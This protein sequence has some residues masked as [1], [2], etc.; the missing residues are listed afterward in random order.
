MKK[1]FFAL[2]VL[3]VAASCGQRNTYVINGEITGENSNLV[4]GN[5][6]LYNKDRE[7]PVRDTAEVIDGKFT[8]K[9]TIDTPQQFYISIGT[10]QS[11][12]PIFLENAKYTIKGNDQ[13]LS[14]AQVKGG[15]SQEL[16]NEYTSVRASLT[17]KY[18]LK[19]LNKQF[20]MSRSN[21]EKDSI[22]GIFDMYEEELNRFKDSLINK[23]LVSHF[24]LSFLESS[25]LE[26]PVD[27]A[28]HLVSLF[29]AAPEF[30]GNRTLERVRKSVEIEKDL[31]IGMPAKDFT[32]KTPDGD[33]LS[34]SDLYGQE[35]KV[36]MIDFWASWCSPCRKLNPTL[37][38]IYKEYHKKGFEIL[39]V[40]L[41]RD[42]DA[43]KNAIKSDNLTWYHVSDLQFWQSEV[44]AL[45]HV[46]YI[47]Q[48]IFLDGNGTIIGRRLDEEEIL[49]LLEQRL[50]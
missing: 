3:C 23:N 44:P 2:A 16:F 43:W 32:L 13:E 39:G 38:K 37:V 47:P 25:I 26:I 49:T 35:N 21:E 40:S 27:S 17:E 6:Y 45:Y 7:F 33:D 11:V 24:T 42:A 30:E 31:Q 1:V 14:K 29:D 36:I 22:I 8:F 9:G 12:I 10:I 46:R 41:D 18:N 34:L 15:K 5:A 19:Q 28:E 50:K 48:N 4:K 20:M